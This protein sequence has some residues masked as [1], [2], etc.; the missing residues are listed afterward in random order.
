MPPL[1][2]VR[3]LFGVCASLPSCVSVCSPTT[4]GFAPFPL[5]VVLSVTSPMTWK[6][7]SLM[8]Q[9]ATSS[10]IFFLA[11]IFRAIFPETREVGDDAARPVVAAFFGLYADGSPCHNSRLI[12]GAHTPC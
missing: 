10:S 3:G 8:S 4:C 6:F 9:A 7:Q 5:L 12:R 11:S 1:A 2:I